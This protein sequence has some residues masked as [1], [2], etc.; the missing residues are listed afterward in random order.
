MKKICS[1]L[2][3]ALVSIS[4]FAQKQTFDVVNYTMP[5]GWDKTAMAQG[6]QLSAKNDGKGNY[7]SVVILSAAATTATAQENFNASWQTL[8]KGTVSVSGEPTMQAPAV[9]KGWDILSGQGNYTD[10]TNKGSVT[11]ITAT[12]NGKM[13]NVVIMTNTNKY[14]NQI[15]DF[16]NSL[17]LNET[18]TAQNNNTNPASAATNSIALGSK[19]AYSITVPPTWSLNAAGN[20]VTLEK[21]TATGKRIIEF[22]SMIKS[23][24]S[25]EKDIEHIFFE[26]FDGWSLYNSSNDQLFELGNHEKGV[27]CQG[28]PYYMLGK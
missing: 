21:N 2:F 11:L 22:M 4:A 28:L 1:V 12:G 18:A 8:V 16:V 19:D 7:A 15:L 26:V 25:L 23:S 6:I 17:D 13:A 10:G 14:Q 3:V 20:N 9:E 27:T 24:G 5:K